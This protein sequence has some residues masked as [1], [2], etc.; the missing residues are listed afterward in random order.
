MGIIFVPLMLALVIHLLLGFWLSTLGIFQQQFKLQAIFKL[1]KRISLLFIPSF[2]LPILF[3]TGRSIDIA[4]IVLLYIIGSLIIIY[5]W[6]KILNGDFLENIQKNI[7]LDYV[8]NFVAGG[9]FPVS[10][11][12]IGDWLQLILNINFRY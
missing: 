3:C 1:T 2:F 9:L 8:A 5:G 4:F 6:I 11:L 7:N 12:F 10:W